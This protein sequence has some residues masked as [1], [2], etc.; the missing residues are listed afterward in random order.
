[1]KQGWIEILDICGS[2]QS[3]IFIAYNDHDQPNNSGRR[4]KENSARLV[5]LIR[6]LKPRSANKVA[7]P[8]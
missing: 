7:S 3:A 5:G 6:G 8:H 1:M 2:K 4:R